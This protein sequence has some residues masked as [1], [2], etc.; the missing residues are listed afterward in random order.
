VNIKRPPHNFLVADLTRVVKYSFCVPHQRKL[1]G[2]IRA[3]N[4][5]RKC[6]QP[7]RHDFDN[8]ESEDFDESSW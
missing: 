2:H 4:F 3:A 5:P 1:L 7:K 8:T 6:N